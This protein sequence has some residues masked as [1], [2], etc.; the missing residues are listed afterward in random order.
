[1]ILEQIQKKLKKSDLCALIMIDTLNLKY[2]TGLTLSSSA[3]I[4]TS[5]SAH[6]FVDERYVLMARRLRPEFQIHSGTKSEIKSSMEP[7]LKGIQ[8]SIGFDGNRVSYDYHQNLLQRVPS[9]TLVSSPSFFSNLRR[10][11]TL[12]EISKIEKACQICEKG[13][14]HLLNYLKPGVTEKELEREI[15]LF[16]FTHGAD[17][18]A[19]PPIIAFGP[20]SACPHWNCS[21]TPLKKN[22][23]VLVDLGVEKDGYTSDMTRIIFYGDVDDE[24]RHCFSHV[25]EAFHR[26]VKQAMPGALPYDL[27]KSAR[28]YLGS[29][30][31]EKAF[32]HSL[33]HGVGIKVHEPPRLS[34]ERVDE[35]ALQIG[36]VITIE[37]GLYI[38]GKGGVRLEDTFVIETKG[39]RSL[40]SLPAK[41]IEIPN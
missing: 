17:D 23:V 33:G 41:L 6:L 1:M 3:L 38:E 39:A 10:K 4:I 2:V 37:P 40:F 20:N 24:L 15:K 35:S 8:G 13:F 29:C 18:T 5:S 36:D 34:P 11:K 27:D 16:W 28:E 32:S 26:A 31:Y 25:E 21:D 14:V 19:F 30:G 9:I 7:V 12:E 22:S